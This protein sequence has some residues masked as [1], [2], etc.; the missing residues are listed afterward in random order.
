M[1]AAVYYGSGDVRVTS[2][3]HPGQ[4]AAGEVLL[5]VIRGALC[6]TD[7]AEY[8]YGPVVIPVHRIHPGSGHSGPVILGHEFLGRVHAV[9]VGV[10]ELQLGQRVVSGSGVFCGTCSWCRAGR[11]NLC[12]RYYT[13]GLQ[14]NGGLAEMVRVPAVICVPVPE[15]CPDD[16]AAMAQ[17]LSVALHALDRSRLTAD[18]TLVVSGVGGI[19]GFVV[20]AAAARG[21]RRI[22]AVDIAA[23]QLES[24]QRLGAT[25]VID[26]RDGDVANAI[27]AGTRQ[28]GADVVAEASGAPGA[29][30]TAVDVTRRGGRTVLVGIPKSPPI[31]D[32]ADVTLRE[33]ELIGTVAHICDQ[34]LPEA[35]QILTSTP[36]LG[37]V[38]DRVI[39]LDDVVTH[40]LEPLRRGQVGGKVLIRTG[41]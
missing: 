26:A 36:S 3:P 22:I 17:P 15:G 41:A 5:E 10:T 28:E 35:L 9:G 21:C 33:L 8:S 6:G 27:L 29:L 12:A 30:A 38:V 31:V 18:E 39:D 20:A 19:G 32:T 40:G 16:A 2:V 13:L 24:A 14:A 1:K 23:A 34:N 4:P 37:A 25:D 7:S 11:P